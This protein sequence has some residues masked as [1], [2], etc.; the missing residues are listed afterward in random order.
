MKK[1]NFKK[2]VIVAILF[3]SV[4]SL[5]L[6]LITLSTKPHPNNSNEFQYS[7]LF[8]VPFKRLPGTFTDYQNSE[9]YIDFVF[10]VSDI[11]AKQENILG[12]LKT[13]E[14][15][16]ILIKNN[17]SITEIIADEEGNIQKTNT[18]RLKPVGSKEF[19][20]IKRLTEKTVVE[21]CELEIPLI[22]S[23]NT[24]VANVLEISYENWDNKTVCI[25]DKNNYMRVEGMFF[26]D[27]SDNVTVTGT[28]PEIRANSILLSVS[29]SNEKTQ[30]SGAVA[31]YSNSAEWESWGIFIT[32]K[33]SRESQIIV[34]RYINI[35]TRVAGDSW[36]GMG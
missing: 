19:S 17:E 34:D 22:N 29:E 8:D 36:I 32:S 26:I 31:A 16:I 9:G 10:S 4:L 18:I 15:N 1:I 20:E 35:E 25:G 13:D 11:E 7:E 2:T 23:N 21:L 5:I 12:L 33:S 14:A 24:P 30:N 28:S 27:S 6:G 3:I